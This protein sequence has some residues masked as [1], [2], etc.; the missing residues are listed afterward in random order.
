[1]LV[2][3]DTNKLAP[4]ELDRLREAAEGLEF[5][6]DHVTVSNREMELSSLPSQAV[7]LLRLPS[8]TSRI[9]ITQSGELGLACVTVE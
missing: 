7:V 6:F 2:T 3:V 5:E 8:G 9:G 1:M 4:A